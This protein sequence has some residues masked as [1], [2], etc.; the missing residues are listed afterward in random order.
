MYLYLTNRENVEKMK[1][2]ENGKGSW[3]GWVQAQ[4]SCRRG[5]TLGRGPRFSILGPIMDSW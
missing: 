2:T 4:G 5:E 3:V 1:T